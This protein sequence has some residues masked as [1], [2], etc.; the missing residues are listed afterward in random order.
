MSLAWEITEDDVAWVL[1]SHGMNKSE[2]EISEIHDDLDHEEIIENLLRYTDM[3]D[4]MNSMY[5]D[6]ENALLESGVIA[7]EKIFHAS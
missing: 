1:R 4:Q 3:E 6:I 5:D 7:G 2:D